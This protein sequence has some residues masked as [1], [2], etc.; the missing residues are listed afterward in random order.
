MSLR[1]LLGLVLVAVVL[2]AAVVREYRLQHRPGV[3]RSAILL[4]AVRMGGILLTGFGL[5]GCL[6]DAA[7][8]GGTGP[9]VEV[10]RIGSVL[11]IPV[12][13][14]GYQEG[15]TRLW[16]LSS[17]AAASGLLLIMACSLLMRWREQRVVG[18]HG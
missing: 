8:F 3:S 15:H 6:L 10:D 1:L 5:L 18:P 11:G 12:G 17:K 16:E 4:H 7:G 2:V 13:G 14:P 9:T